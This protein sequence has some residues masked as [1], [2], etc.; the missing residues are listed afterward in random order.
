M[1]HGTTQSLGAPVLELRDL[2][3]AYGQ[4]QVVRGFSLQVDAAECLALIG[5]NGA[6]KS[7]LF[8]LISG[9]VKPDRGEVFLQGQRIDGLRPFEVNRRG[10]ARSFQV[11][12]LFW[13]LSVE[14]NLRCAVLCRLGHGLAFW[15]RLA[16]ARGV[17][18]ETEHWLGSLGL[19]PRRDVPA[20]ALSYGEQRALELG[21]ALA[22]GAGVVLLD[23]PTAGMSR[24][25]TTHFVALIR[26]LTRG[27]TLLI[28]EHDMGVVFELADRIAVMVRGEL[29]VCATPP[30][31]RA[32]PRVQ[33]AYLGQALPC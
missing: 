29:L 7:S 33:Q 18:D 10:L 2:H 4:T 14:D 8:N 28:V 25:E 20:S 30:L 13:R 23:E 16:S 22:G 6:G 5:P 11:S 32:D 3:L 15:K 24:T 9:Q 1:S 27:K 26:Q 19:V 17:R 31:V 12:Q 21:L